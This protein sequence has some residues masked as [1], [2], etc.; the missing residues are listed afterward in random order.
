MDQGFDTMHCQATPDVTAPDGSDVRI[1]RPARG[2]GERSA[3]LADDQRDVA[4]GAA[5]VAA[6]ARVGRLTGATTPPSPPVTPGGPASA[7]AATGAMSYA[8]KESPDPFGI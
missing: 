5:L 2:S 7:G 8:G 6:V 1:L 3:R 4:L